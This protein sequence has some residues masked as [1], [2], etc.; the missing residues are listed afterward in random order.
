MIIILMTNDQGGE[1]SGF[2]KGSR[3][4]HMERVSHYGTQDTHFKKA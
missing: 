3:I 2:F 1:D 4:K